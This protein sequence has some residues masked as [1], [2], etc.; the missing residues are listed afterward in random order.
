MDTKIIAHIE[1]EFPEKFGIPRQSG[2]VE[3]LRARIVFTPEYRVPEAVRGLEDFSHLWL[4][5]Q[6]SKAVRETWSPTVRPP[7]LG[8]NTRMGVF[9]TRSPFRPNAIGLSCVKL[10]SVE[11]HTDR[12]PII[13]VAGADLMDGTPIFDIKPYIP[14]ADCH[15]EATGGF[16]DTAGSFLL[17]VDFPEALLKLVPEEHRAAL[18]G[19]LSH[20]PRPSYQNAPDRVYGMAFGGVN[21]KFRVNGNQLTVVDVSL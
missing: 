3:E 1:S 6:F 13:T 16:T 15:P 8:G 5:W 9:A 19:V 17:E 10:I 20:D 2:L 14:Y 7:R 21:V 11:P 18:M 4:I 12:G